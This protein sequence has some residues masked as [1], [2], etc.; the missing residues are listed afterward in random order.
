MATAI[1]RNG[2]KT[3]EAIC[4]DGFIEKS[5]ARARAGL[6]VGISASS[7]LV[8]LLPN[9]GGCWMLSVMV[10]LLHRIS[11]NQ[12]LGIW[13]VKHSGICILTRQIYIVENSLDTSR[14]G[15]AKMWS[16]G[17]ISAP[18]LNMHGPLQLRQSS[19][20]PPTPPTPP[21]VRSTAAKSNSAG[22]SLRVSSQPA[23][24][25]SPSQPPPHRSLE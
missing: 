4:D 10:M 14:S 3:V 15:Y 25:P 8:L 12:L 7:A 20:T 19:P 1:L 24:G 16:L 2:R 18:P 21:A 13:V 6:I 23:T 11:M 22:E 5:K 9:S 17:F